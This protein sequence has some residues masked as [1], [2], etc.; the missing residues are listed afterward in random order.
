[1]SLRNKATLLQLHGVDYTIQHNNDGK[2]LMAVDVRA[3]DKR[4]YATWVDLTNTNIKQ[5]L[6]Y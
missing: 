2:R 1:M 5:W 3:D 4:V 6:G